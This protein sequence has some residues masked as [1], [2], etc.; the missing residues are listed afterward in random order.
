GDSP[1]VQV[2]AWLLPVTAI[3]AVLGVLWQATTMVI[4]RRGEPLLIIVKALAAVALWGAVGIIGTQLV[5]WAGDAYTNWI[6]MHAIGGSPDDAGG[7]LAVNL[8][9]VVVAG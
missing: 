3:V 6:L 5:L 9:A 8:A 1:A 7:S 2:R 4:S